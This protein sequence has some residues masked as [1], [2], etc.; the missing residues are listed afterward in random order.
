MLYF[1]FSLELYLAYLFLFV[2]L[3]FSQLIHSIDYK[4]YVILK[5]Q[6]MVEG[7]YG[8]PGSGKTYM[9]AKIGLEAIR[10]KREVFANFKLTGAH[11]F[12]DI[13]D[14]INIR[15]GVILIDEINLSFPSRIWD[16]LPPQFLYFWSQTR[17][18]QLDIFFTSQHPDR[19]DKVPKE[20]SNWGWWIVKLPFGFH[21]ARKYLPEH[22]TKERRRNYEIRFF[23]RKREV[24]LAFNTMELIELPKH[25]LEKYQRSRY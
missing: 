6:E 17:K 10:Q 14:V 13:F 16:K 24:M 21:M 4:K 2:W 1:G 7:F 20:I 12:N 18:M 23:K 3:V 11:Y 25:L 8:L 19:V 15:N 9:L 22:I 5:K